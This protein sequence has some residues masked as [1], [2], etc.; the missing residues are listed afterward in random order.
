MNFHGRGFLARALKAVRAARASGLTG[1]LRSLHLFILRSRLRLGAEPAPPPLFRGR[2]SA[3]NPPAARLLLAGGRAREAGTALAATLRE[4]P[5]DENACGLMAEA[6]LCSGREDEAFR[7]MR[8]KARSLR[9]PGFRAWLG[10]LLLFTGRYAGA[11]REL[12]PGK[13]GASPMSRCWRG[14]A[15]AALGRTG[16]ALRELRAAL[17]AD[18]DDLEARIWLAEALLRSGR[19]AAAAEEAGKALAREPGNP[20]AL[21]LAGLSAQ[22]RGD[23]ALRKAAR[24]LRGP[25]ARAAGAGWALGALERARGCRRSE[26][27]FIRM[28]TGGT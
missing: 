24:I 17:A 12:G 19:S 7:L 16:E 4:F 11:L 26:R 28:A 10:Q 9:S 8:G 27:H 13:G 22:G 23:A 21:I 15:L 25:A 1:K 14:A 2:L 20:W 18:P 6:L 3:L 5:L